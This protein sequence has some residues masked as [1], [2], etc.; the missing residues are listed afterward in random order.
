MKNWIYSILIGSLLL[1]SLPVC[2]QNP[3][4]GSGAGYST[5]NATVLSMM[6]W[7]LGLAAG[8]GLLCGYL[9]DSEST[10]SH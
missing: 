9:F 2:A 1:Y 7:G 5:R 10:H 4:E 8:I 3:E 6:G